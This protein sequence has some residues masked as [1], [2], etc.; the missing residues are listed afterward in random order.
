MIGLSITSPFVGLYNVLYNV[1]CGFPFVL[2]VNNCSRCRICCDGPDNLRIAIADFCG[3]VASAYI[4]SVCGF[5]CRFV[6]AV[7]VE[8]EE[9]EGRRGRGRVNGW[10]VVGREERFRDSARILCVIC[11]C[12]RVEGE[13]G[14]RERGGRKK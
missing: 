3:G 7:D 14:D 11:V 1:V 5:G 10:D 6:V 4:V 9:E 13:M 12:V 8:E 2:C